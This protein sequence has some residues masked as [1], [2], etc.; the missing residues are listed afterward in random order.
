MDTTNLFRL[1]GKVALVTGGSRLSAPMLGSLL[2]KYGS[3]SAE[4]PPNGPRAWH[5]VQLRDTSSRTIRCSASSG[6][7]PAVSAAVRSK[8]CSGV[9]E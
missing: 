2:T 6:A 4:T 7:E 8:R 3:R 1:D 9:S 5:A